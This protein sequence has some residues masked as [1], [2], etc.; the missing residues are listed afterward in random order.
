MN[1][2]AVLMVM[3][4]LP[5][6]LG[7]PSGQGAAD[8]RNVQPLAPVVALTALLLAVRPPQWTRRVPAYQTG[9]LAATVLHHQLTL[10]P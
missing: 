8:W 4:M 5:H 6:I 1:G 2:V 3:A 9:L 7:L 10:T